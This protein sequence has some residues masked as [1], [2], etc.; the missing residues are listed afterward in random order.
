MLA[1]PG[2][3]LSIKV[4]EIVLRVL[5]AVRFQHVPQILEL[6]LMMFH[7][8]PIY[9]KWGK[10]PKCGYCL[11]RLEQVTL[12]VLPVLLSYFFVHLTLSWIQGGRVCWSCWA[13]AYVGSYSSSGEATSPH[14]AVARAMCERRS[15]RKNVVK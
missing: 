4:T 10:S 8:P 6:L 15:V 13:S 2:S 7:A 12:L 11:A 5:Q 9:G 3:A 14:A 1:Q